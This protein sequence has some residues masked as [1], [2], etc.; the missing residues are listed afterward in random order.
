MTKG[1]LRSMAVAALRAEQIAG[2]NPVTP[3]HL[4]LAIK[5]MGGK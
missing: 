5:M 1:N 4:R 2:D 3:S